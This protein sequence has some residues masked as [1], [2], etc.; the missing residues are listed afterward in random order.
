M[1]SEAPQLDA[2]DIVRILKSTCRYPDITGDLTA[3]G[4]GIIDAYAA[5]KE[6]KNQ[7]CLVLDRSGSMDT[8]TG[9]DEKTRLEILQEAAGHLVDKVDAGSSLATIAFNDVEDLISPMTVISDPEIVGPEEPEAGGGT[10]S[11]VRESL[12]EAISGLAAEGG[13]SI[14]L[15]VLKARSQLGSDKVRKAIIV[16]SDGKETADPRLSTVSAGAGDIVV[17]SIGMGTPEDMEPTGLM[18]LTAGTGGY[19]IHE[20]Q[21]FSNGSNAISKFLTQIEGEISGYEPVVDPALRFRAGDRQSIPFLLGAHDW[22]GEIVLINPGNAPLSIE[23]KTPAG[24]L[25]KDS[26]ISATRNGDVT[27]YRFRKPNFPPQAAKGFRGEWSVEVSLPEDRY[28]EWLDGLG[29]ARDEAAAFANE[30]FP[31]TLVVQARSRLKMKCRIK[32]SSYEPGAVMT[33][34]VDLDQDRKPVRAAEVVTVQ[35]TTPDKKV[36]SPAPDKRKDG[37][38]TWS[39]TA[40]TPGIYRWLVSARGTLPGGDLIQR[41]IRLT[42]LSGKHRPKPG[43]GRRAFPANPDCLFFPDRTASKKA[44]D[45]GHPLPS[46]IH[47]KVGIRAPHQP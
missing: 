16:V 47:L 22:A 37:A 17:Y 12:K 45:P 32:Q 14:A 3:Y 5:L 38:M 8:V 30:G 2:T 6:L 7:V 31:C 27:R 25:M 42:G 43:T 33:L 41:R 18:A 36:I 20:D 44:G 29:E 26:E 9:P 23:L 10:I 24:K 40:D 28:G 4:K 39:A 19:M 13:T 11:P 21:L 34:R 1:W 15:G 35:V 46:R